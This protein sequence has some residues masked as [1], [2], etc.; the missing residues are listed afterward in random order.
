MAA[1]T[2]LLQ[3]WRDIRSECNGRLAGLIRGQQRSRGKHEETRFHNAFIIL[4]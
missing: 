3:D 1:L 2:A 4:L